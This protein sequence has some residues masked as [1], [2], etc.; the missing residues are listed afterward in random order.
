M[1]RAKGNEFIIVNDPSVKNNL[2]CSLELRDEE[3][4]GAKIEKDS[5]WA[6]WQLS[7]ISRLWTEDWSRDRGG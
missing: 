1:K 3:C 6:N 5:E 2:L 7:D 4:R